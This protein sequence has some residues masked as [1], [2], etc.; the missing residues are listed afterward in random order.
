MDNVVLPEKEKEWENVVR[1]AG[2]AVGNEMRNL[3]HEMPT[4]S[5]IKINIEK[6]S[7]EKETVQREEER[8][9]ASQRKLTKLS[10][11]MSREEKKMNG[12]HGSKT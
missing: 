9:E 12:L 5:L 3:R 2:S 10:Q 8:D 4:T 1:E 6:K 11:N 7:G